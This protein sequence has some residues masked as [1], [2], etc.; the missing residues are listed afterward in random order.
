[1][2]SINL[3]QFRNNFFFISDEKLFT[4]LNFDAESYQFLAY[5]ALTHS[6]D[7]IIPKQKRP[8]PAF[9][10]DFR[11]YAHISR[12]YIRTVFGKK[13]SENSQLYSFFFGL[14]LFIIWKL[15]GGRRF[16]PLIST[17]SKCNYYGFYDLHFTP[18]ALILSTLPTIKWAIGVSPAA[19]TGLKYFKYYNIFSIWGGPLSEADRENQ[20]AVIRASNKNS[21]FV[22]IEAF[23]FIC[24]ALLLKVLFF[25]PV[26]FLHFFVRPT[27]FWLTF[28]VYYFAQKFDSRSRYIG[29]LPYDYFWKKVYFLYFSSARRAIVIEEQGIS[30]QEFDARESDFVGFSYGDIVL[31]NNR[32]FSVLIHRL[33]VHSLRGYK[34]D[35]FSSFFSGYYLTAALGQLTVQTGVLK[36]S[37]SYFIERY[38]DQTLQHAFSIRPAVIESK[39]SSASKWVYKDLKVKPNFRL[40]RNEDKDFFVFVRQFNAYVQ[41]LL[42]IAESRKISLLFTPFYLNVKRR[43]RFIQVFELKFSTVSFRIFKQLGYVIA[44][45]LLF[46][47]SLAVILLS[48]S[49]FSDFRNRFNANDRTIAGTLFRFFSKLGSLAK[50][51]LTF[52]IITFSLIKFYFQLFFEYFAVFF[53]LVYNFIKK[54]FHFNAY[55]SYFYF[56]RRYFYGFFFIRFFTREVEDELDQMQDIADLSDEF[57]VEEEFSSPD[58]EFQDYDVGF[59]KPL[60]YDEFDIFSH[61]DY[62]DKSYTRSGADNHIFNSDSRIENNALLEQLFWGWFSINY[63]ELSIFL[64]RQSKDYDR[65]KAF[66]PSPD[67]LGDSLFGEYQPVTNY[68]LDD[69]HYSTDE[70]QLEEDDY[71][72]FYYDPEFMESFERYYDY[73][74]TDKTLVE[75]NNKLLS[76]RLKLDKWHTHISK[77]FVPIPKEL[78]L[79]PSH[80]RQPNSIDDWKILTLAIST[81]VLHESQ[82]RVFAAR[83]D[84]EFMNSVWSKFSKAIKTHPEKVYQ[85]LDS[86]DFERRYELI[87]KQFSI[88]PKEENFI[89][90]IFFPL[91]GSYIAEKLKFF[92]STI[93][94]DS[95]VR[96]KSIIGYRHID[97]SL[98][99]KIY[100][101]FVSPNALDSATLDSFK[102]EFSEISRFDVLSVVFY[103]RFLADSDFASF[104][105]FINTPVGSFIWSK[106]EASFNLATKYSPRNYDFVS[107]DDSIVPTL[108][109]SLQLESLISIYLETAND[110]EYT[111]HNFTVESLFTHTIR[112]IYALFNIPYDGLLAGNEVPRPGHP[113]NAFGAG[114][115]NED[116][117]NLMVDSGTTGPASNINLISTLFSDFVYSYFTDPSVAVTLFPFSYVDFIDDVTEVDEMDIGLDIDDQYILYETDVSTLDSISFYVNEDNINDDAIDELDTFDPTDN[118]DDFG[119]M[120]DPAVFNTDD[121]ETSGDLPFYDN[122]L[123]LWIDDNLEGGE[124]WEP[125]ELDSADDVSL[126]INRLF[127]GTLV[128]SSTT[129]PATDYRLYS[130]LFS[131]SKL[132][133]TGYELD[134]A[135][136]L[137][138]AYSSKSTKDLAISQ[139]AYAFASTNTNFEN[140]VTTWAVS[141]SFFLSHLVRLYFYI[142]AFFFNITFYTYSK[143]INHL[144]NVLIFKH[145]SKNSLTYRA[146]LDFS[147]RVK[148]WIYGYED[149]Y[150]DEGYFARFRDNSLDYGDTYQGPRSNMF[151]R[152][153]L[154]F[155]Y[156]IPF[157]DFLFGTDRDADYEITDF[158]V[159]SQQDYIDFDNLNYKDTVDLYDNSRFTDV[160]VLELFHIELEESAPLDGLLH[161]EQDWDIGATY[162]YSSD[163]FIDDIQMFNNRVSIFISA[164]SSLFSLISD[165]YLYFFKV[166]TSKH[167]FNPFY[168]WNVRSSYE[169]ARLAATYGLSVYF[170]RYFFSIAIIF[171]ISIYAYF[172]FPRI[173][174]WFFVHTLDYGLFLFANAIFTF[175]V[176]FFAWLIF[177]PNFANF[178]SNFSK[179]EKLS[180]HFLIITIWIFYIFGSYTRFPWF[181]LVQDNELFRNLGTEP[182]IYPE[183]FAREYQG[184]VNNPNL[185]SNK[186]ITIFDARSERELVYDSEKF[187]ADYNRRVWAFTFDYRTLDFGT[188]IDAIKYNVLGIRNSYFT[189]YKYMHTNYD[190]MFSRH[191]IDAYHSFLHRHYIVNLGGLPR[192]YGKFMKRQTLNQFD[193]IRALDVAYSYSVSLASK[194]ESQLVD[195][196]NYMIED[197]F[198][199]HNDSVPDYPYDFRPDSFYNSTDDYYSQL[200]TPEYGSILKVS[201]E[202]TSYNTSYTTPRK[203][204][205]FYKGRRYSRYNYDGHA[206][207]RRLSSYIYRY[208]RLGR[209]KHYRRSVPGTDQSSIAAHFYDQILRYR[210]LQNNIKKGQFLFDYST[211]FS[212]FVLF[213][214]FSRAKGYIDMFTF[215]PSHLYPRSTRRHGHRKAFYNYYSAVRDIHYSDIYSEFDLLKRKYDEVKDIIAE[216][217]FYGNWVKYTKLSARID[218]LMKQKTFYRAHVSRLATAK[219]SD[220]YKPFFNF[221]LYSRFVYHY[222]NYIIMLY[223]HVKE[224]YYLALTRFTD[225]Y[226]RTASEFTNYFAY[227]AGSGAYQSKFTRSP[228]VQS[229][230]SRDPKRLIRKKYCRDGKDLFVSTSKRFSK[231]RTPVDVFYSNYSYKLKHYPRRAPFQ[232]RNSRSHDKLLYQRKLYFYRRLPLFRQRYKKFFTNTLRYRTVI[233]RKQFFRRRLKKRRFFSKTVSSIR[234]QNI[235][236]NYRVYRDKWLYGLKSFNKT[237]ASES[238]A[239][240]SVREHE[241]KFN[242]AVKKLGDKVPITGVT[243][244]LEVKPHTLPV[245]FLVDFSNFRKPNFSY[246]RFSPIN[247][248]FNNLQFKLLKTD[249]KLPQSLFQ[250]SGF[251]RDENAENNQDVRI[252]GKGIS[253]MED[254]NRIRLF[255]AKKRFYKPYFYRYLEVRT[256]R[257]YK[258]YRIF[259]A[260]KKQF[261]EEFIRSI[262]LPALDTSEPVVPR[263]NKKF[264][265]HHSVLRVR[266]PKDPENFITYKRL[267][268][269]VPQR[270]PKK[271]QIQH[272]YE[273]WYKRRFARLVYNWQKRSASQTKRRIL[274]NSRHYTRIGDRYD[275]GDYKAYVRRYKPRRPRFYIENRLTALFG[276]KYNEALGEAETLLAKEKRRK[277]AALK[278]L[279][280]KQKRDLELAKARQK[281]LE[282]RRAERRKSTFT[283]DNKSHVNGAFDATDDVTT[284]FE[285]ESFKNPFFDNDDPT[286]FM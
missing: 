284:G 95:K 273:D 154:N 203:K 65:F 114:F 219:K 48:T 11:V 137:K 75:L 51:F 271:L 81:V 112:S 57:E 277:K 244:R 205:I 46:P 77:N 20:L 19:M 143:D 135:A 5:G 122:D 176:F 58:F 164:L 279:R 197:T 145:F 45:I 246:Y 27:V 99:D 202:L 208:G 62:Y 168:Y 171:S 96:L 180:F 140:T 181:P 41:Y 150:R 222:N 286:K 59:E 225:K 97:F 190:F 265:V 229:K 182:E 109:R 159:H 160:D 221:L 252:M 255:R 210:Y 87:E 56:F 33:G 223:P 267:K 40:T 226:L 224:N 260:I 144:K 15:G 136:N 6:L 231:L 239:I 102:K 174:Y 63:A 7:P 129:L 263:K 178:Y 64:F 26:L 147:D 200:Y 218:H 196:T 123:E 261:S 119:F 53:R 262:L 120:T 74:L 272:N 173:F 83:S 275:I 198:S 165:Y 124:D 238:K 91:F 259:L 230:F 23:R 242:V 141:I 2:N 111:L 37:S 156:H 73:V 98:L 24:F 71:E 54:I 234:Y 68:G 138:L 169:W 161:E 78:L 209:F 80:L 153:F 258:P 93:L 254:F 104:Y 90:K 60:S 132:A 69:E 31:R 245:D 12:I 149:F 88:L 14:Y 3:K 66:D 35:S 193:R 248:A 276:P 13:F 213:R 227:L 39:R 214:N 280:E 131:N 110:D 212:K 253:I 79:I 55:Y 21:F 139:N 274:R 155:G 266:N 134:Y 44:R 179:D 152:A 10:Y 42:Q 166:K 76:Y 29:S 236:N 36:Y 47:L 67:W 30:P 184:D 282:L 151:D 175:F 270:I 269:V 72:E 186:S 233:R 94:V 195:P 32:I 241:L 194:E 215:R 22:N 118:Q 82:D 243:D 281:R 85:Q 4:I 207:K 127:F 103:L 256:N 177:F 130:G 278:R 204:I 257:K 170:I 108:R 235:F 133:D 162:T 146:P 217:R 17:Y 188:F 116:T 163:D 84:V 167:V 117:W 206:R 250:F 172:V 9:A 158:L 232:K 148:S 142:V 49:I 107:Y 126:P 50:G 70:E 18:L 128:S 247:H 89:N 192:R 199:N 201:R 113:A 240:E 61:D 283:S 220:P 187:L 101:S 125:E 189:G 38:K 25:L 92:F 268:K 52:P 43:S 16:L 1:M 157:S 264:F 28:F 86:V 100:L 185:E 121:T 237:T 8:I 183:P 34:P 285:E 216:E 106:F 251:E 105:K 249:D 115:D 191:I 228:L 211:N